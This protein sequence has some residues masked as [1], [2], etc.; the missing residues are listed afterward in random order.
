MFL[1]F[2]SFF[3]PNK[4]KTKSQNI[5]FRRFF[6]AEANCKPPRPWRVGGEEVDFILIHVIFASEKR[7]KTVFCDFVLILLGW[8]N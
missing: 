2:S 3:H 8:K 5:V 6:A 1:I 4:I 7:L